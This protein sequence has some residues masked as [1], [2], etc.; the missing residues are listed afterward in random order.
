MR[1]WAGAAD[2]ANLVYPVM[3]LDW[4]WAAARLHGRVTCLLRREQRSTVKR[5]LE[6]TLGGMN[7]SREIDTLTKQFFEHKRVRNLLISL[8]P[9]FTPSE[10][11][12]LLRIDGLE[13]LDAALD[14]KRGVILLG[15]HLNS[16]CL[17]LLVISLRE[18]GYDVRTA[19]PEPKDPW[20]PTAVGKILNRYYKAPTVAEA[21][22]AFYAQFNIRPIV[23][24]LRDN[25]VVAQTGD[26]LHSARFVEV[27]F[28]GRRMPFPTGMASVA[29]VT[30]AVVVP[31]FQVGSPP[32]GLRSVIEEP[33]TVKREVEAEGALHA[34]VA[35]YA[36]RLEHYLL[37]NLASWEHW[38]I[39]DTLATAA[40]WPQKS[41]KERYEI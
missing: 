16:V 30:G 19:L 39:E 8:A 2:A 6:T 26:G 18:H 36:R 13:H 33:W 41:L 35:A 15:S 31:V 5:N 29:Q 24:C 21:M 3:P 10:K 11:A 22:A 1:K 12:A 9:R 14:E 28:L 40:A 27:D 20:P 25:A 7:T 4:L 23:R 17:F 38:L 32:H 37:E 34:A